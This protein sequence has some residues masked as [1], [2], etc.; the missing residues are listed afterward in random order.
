M[1]NIK[2]RDLAIGFLL[3][4]QFLTFSGDAFAQVTLSRFPPNP[5]VLPGGGWQ[6]TNGTTFGDPPGPRAWVNGKYG[7]VPQFKATDLYLLNGPAGKLPASAVTAVGLAGAAGAV[8]RCV[9][10]LNP[11]CAVGTAAWLAYDK[12][13][14]RPP[15]GD[16][17]V[18]G[19][20]PCDFPSGQF[21]YDPGQSPSNQTLTQHRCG[22]ANQTG[23]AYGYSTV[24]Y[25]EACNKHKENVQAVWVSSA[26]P[27]GVCGAA[28]CYQN[29]TVGGFCGGTP[30]APLGI[31]TKS[32]LTWSG[33]GAN[34]P[35]SW[36]CQGF[37]SGDA[38]QQVT[39]Q[40]CPASIDPFNSAYSIP[41]GAPVGPDGK[42][43]TARYNHVPRTP[44]QVAD[45]INNFPPDLPDAT[46]GQGV[47]DA[48]DKGGQQAAPGSITSGGPATQTGSPTVITTQ[49]PDGTT[50]TETKTP[51]VSYTYN[52]PTITYTTTNTTTTNTCTGAGSC[53]TGGTTTTTVPKPT[54]QDPLDPCT[55]NPE[56]AG[57]LKIGDPGTNKPEST[58][59]QVD[60]TPEDLGLGAFCPQPFSFVVHGWTMGFSYQMACDNAPVIRLAVLALAA[61][62]CA[63]LIIATVTKT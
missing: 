24:S 16:G 44:E 56:R 48:I 54:E 20:V 9:I 47:S 1:V 26:Q 55:A 13:R 12:Y 2:P 5:G 6:F 28:G 61:F 53:T 37:S 22:Q 10:G 43:P 21:D 57:C 30:T 3:V 11:V 39:Q 42:C 31:E 8:G 50:K 60:Y 14:A 58:E 25:L 27:Y 52:G 46:W 63:T 38:P 32:W 45:I 18:C 49:N 40:G 51:N 36:T 4:W 62:G 15:E 29:R 35:S 23:A 19:G 17:Y 41:A 33:S 59:K 34:V 7:G